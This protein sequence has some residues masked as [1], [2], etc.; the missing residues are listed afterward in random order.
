MAIIEEV[1]LSAN[2]RTSIVRAI[3]KSRGD[4]ASCRREVKPELGGLSIAITRSDIWRAKARNARSVTQTG[5]S[6]LS[7][8]PSNFC[9][10]SI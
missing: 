8:N 9:F 5:E 2:S 3:L 4:V 10:P 1:N 7:D 6:M